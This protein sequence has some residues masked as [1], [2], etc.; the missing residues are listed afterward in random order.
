MLTAIITNSRF[1]QILEE[2]DSNSQ[3]RKRKIAIHKARGDN[4]KVRKEIKSTWK[5]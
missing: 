1:L 3:A 2:D 5:L 4:A